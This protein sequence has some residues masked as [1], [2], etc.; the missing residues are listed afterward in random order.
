MQQSFF[1]TTLGA[2]TA[3]RY[4]HISIWCTAMMDN[5][6]TYLMTAYCKPNV[7]FTANKCISFSQQCWLTKI[8]VAVSFQLIVY[9]TYNIKITKRYT[10]VV[11]MSL[12]TNNE[13]RT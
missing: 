2:Y 7:S 5:K 12:L 4:V 8:N 1:D 6:V 3:S 10:T 9:G 13:K 11:F